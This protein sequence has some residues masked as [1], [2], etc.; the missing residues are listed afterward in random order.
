[1]SLVFSVL[2]VGV[3]DR[4]LLEFAPYFAEYRARITAAEKHLQP[5]LNGIVEIYDYLIAK[6][7]ERTKG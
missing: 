2:L 7:D 4:Y 5:A 1:M 6:V 3:A